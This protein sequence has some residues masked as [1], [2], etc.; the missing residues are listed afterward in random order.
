MSQQ[1]WTVNPVDDDIT[2][3]GDISL[4]DLDNDGDLDI[5]L[6]G[7]GVDQMIWYEN[8][9]E[10]PVEQECEL[11]SITPGSVKTGL[12]ILPRFNVVTIAGNDFSDF[13]ADSTVEIETEGVTVLYS[14]AVD[15][16]TIQA[17]IM[18]WGAEKG[19]Y[20]VSVDS[21]SGITFTVE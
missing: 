16:Q 21:C 18:T 11:N 1:S 6:A 7:M 10:N 4:D 17:F 2:F 20:N 3:P 19:T 13:N 14:T 9:L 8:K 5:V 15:R 12:G